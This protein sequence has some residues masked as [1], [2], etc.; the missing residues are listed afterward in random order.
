MFPHGVVDSAV[1]YRLPNPSMTAA[2]ASRDAVAIALEEA[3]AAASNAA[4][5]GEAAPR[6]S[7]PSACWQR[8]CCSPNTEPIQAAQVAEAGEEAGAALARIL[9]VANEV[10]DD[11][12]VRAAAD[13][14]TLAPCSNGFV[15]FR[16][17]LARGIA[18]RSSYLRPLRVS[19]AP[20]PRGLIHENVAAGAADVAGCNPRRWLF[21]LICLCLLLFWT[22]PVI[23]FSSLTK[24][25][26]LEEQ[27]PWLNATLT[28][29]GP[30]SREL[31]QGFLPTLAIT[32]FMAVLPFL[33]TGLATSLLR[34]RS[35]SAVSDTTT[36]WYV[37][38]Q[39]VNVLFVSALA[40]GVVETIDKIVK[41]PGALVDLLGTAVP[42]TYFFFT[43]YLMLQAFSVYPLEL[44]QFGALFGKCWA[45]RSA[46]TRR[47]RRAV[48]GPGTAITGGF[49][50]QWGYV[51]LSFAIALQFATVAPLLL[52]FGV[53]FFGLAGAT[54][55]HHLYFVYKFEFDGEGRVFEWVMG[56]LCVVT[57]ISQITLI[58]VFYEKGARWQASLTWLVVAVVAVFWLK[59]RQA[60]RNTFDALPRDPREDIE[61]HKDGGGRSGPISLIVESESYAHLVRSGENASFAP[62]P[63]EIEA[64]IPLVAAETAAEAYL[65]PDIL[66]V[67]LGPVGVRTEVP[68]ESAAGR[69]GKEGADSDDCCFNNYSEVFQVQREKSGGG[70][71]GGG[72]GSGKQDRA[73]EEE[74]LLGSTDGGGGGRE[75]RAEMFLRRSNVLWWAGSQFSAFL[76]LGAIILYFHVAHKNRPPVCQH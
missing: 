22:L 68:G 23:F 58:G 50:K 38:F 28:A 73:E 67:R 59:Q 39:L 4:S 21:S 24:L 26:A 25:E 29:A 65:H 47:Q 30:K 19:P 42:D 60:Y 15:V 12:K 41:R 32:V 70:G 34:L 27:L 14:Q 76:M 17:T 2:L 51:M 35:K 49:A 63:G 6:Y 52:P 40:G 69:E 64:G 55:R 66:R 74:N 53:L 18:L 37:S 36:A 57:I 33:L 20:E 8:C 16:T 75:E 44:V 71:G 1:V 56:A 9:A 10:V 31:L 45:A 3:R 62:L 7:P 72:G 43:S 5:K 46:Q 13:T 61:T 48:V 11:E 54:L